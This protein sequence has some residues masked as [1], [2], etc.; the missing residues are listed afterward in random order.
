MYIKLKFTYKSLN[1]ILV[2]V[3]VFNKKIIK[4][5]KSNDILIWNLLQLYTH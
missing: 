4:P 2:F 3:W 1:S 5:L